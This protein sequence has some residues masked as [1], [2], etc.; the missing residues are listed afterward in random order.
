[1]FYHVKD[2]SSKEKVL[3]TVITK[4]LKLLEK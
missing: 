1:M 3:R 2:V 4:W